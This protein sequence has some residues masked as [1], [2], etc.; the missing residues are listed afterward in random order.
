MP[1]LYYHLFLNVLFDSVD[2][3]FLNANSGSA[4]SGIYYLALTL[5]MIFSSFKESVISALTPWVFENMKIDTQKVR[6]VFNLI[7]ICTGLMGF[8][9]SL[10]YRKF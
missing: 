9:I 5:A 8:L 2:K 7:M 1:F 4:D 10:F 6:S 3:L